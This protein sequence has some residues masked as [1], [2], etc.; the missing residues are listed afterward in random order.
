MAGN[1]W[2]KVTGSLWRTLG[3][4]F[5]RRSADMIVKGGVP[6]VAVENDKDSIVQR[7]HDAEK[8]WTLVLTE[9]SAWTEAVPG[10][11]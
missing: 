11:E 4:V 2:G 7:Q 5:M 6:K 8:K 10:G 9:W 3:N 1:T